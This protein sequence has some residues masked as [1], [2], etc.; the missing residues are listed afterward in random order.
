MWL[1]LISIDEDAF[2]AFLGPLSLSDRLKLSRTLRCRSTISQVTEARKISKSS[3]D[4]HKAHT[5]SALVVFKEAANSATSET[6]AGIYF[7]V[8]RCYLT[9]HVELLSESIAL[10]NC[11]LTD[12][13]RAARSSS[14][15]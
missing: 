6:P 7:L 5:L 10:Q 3:G 11:K 13:F 1:H 14:L 9:N 15:F 2:G 12:N 4:L 8:G